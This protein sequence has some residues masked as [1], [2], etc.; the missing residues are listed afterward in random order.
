MT[1]EDRVM[2][3]LGYWSPTGNFES[4]PSGMVANC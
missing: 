2:V 3:G 4:S 1:K